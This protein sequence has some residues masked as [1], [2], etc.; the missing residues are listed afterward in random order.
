MSVADNYESLLGSVMCYWHQNKALYKSTS[1]TL[2]SEGRFL[3][4][5]HSQNQ[6]FP[7]KLIKSFKISCTNI[8]L[9]INSG[10]Y[11]LLHCIFSSFI[12]ILNC[13]AVL[14]WCYVQGSQSAAHRPLATL[15]V[16]LG[17]LQA[18]WESTV[19]AALSYSSTEQNQGSNLFHINSS[20]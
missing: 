18:F 15:G 9:A 11:L 14:A 10:L 19:Q 17:G 2:Y 8:L 5:L 3:L 1:F 4:W 7:V 16:I 6:N 13:L 20:F 12:F